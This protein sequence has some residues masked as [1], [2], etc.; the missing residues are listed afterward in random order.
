MIPNL[1]PLLR[2]KLRL[3]I[4]PCYNKDMK[5]LN[6]KKFIWGVNNIGYQTEGNNHASNWHRWGSRGLVPDC[7]KANNYWNDFEKD[8]DLVQELG[9]DA[10]RISLEWSRI[11]PVEG[12]FDLEAIRHYR[13]I[14]IDLKKRNIKTAVG[15]W[16]WSVPMWFEEKYG[17]HHEEAP[18]IFL[19]YTQFVLDNLGDWIDILIIHNE[20][21][22]LVGMGYLR[23]EH[24]PFNK[25]LW[26]AWKVAKNFILIYKK[27]YRL[28]HRYSKNILVGSTHLV[29]HYYPISSKNSL[30]YFLEK[31][32]IK[33]SKY[34]RF[35]YLLKRIGEYQ[36]FIGINYYRRS[37]I[38][39][40][41]KILKFREIDNPHDPQ[42]WKKFPAGIYDITREIYQTYKKPIIILENGKPIDCLL[43]DDNRVEFIREIIRYLDKARKDKVKLWGYFHYSL[44]DAYEWTGGYEYFFG[45]VQVD[46][47]SLAR[48][49]RKSFYAYQEIIK[50]SNILN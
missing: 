7:G 14:L 13:E 22:V 30:N 29:N 23:G 8:H 47:K 48:T 39:F 44:T 34:F 24:P 37:A 15:L 5:N 11:E 38:K 46:R 26:R 28:T 18:K 1:F 40:D 10:L 20:P 45:L 31:L 25:N 4:Y 41:Y 42:G 3:T 16:H 17:L 49:K 32:A 36:D 19:S 27:V 50:K 35:D 6:L 9:A 21:M 43:D 2:Y 12:K 33:I